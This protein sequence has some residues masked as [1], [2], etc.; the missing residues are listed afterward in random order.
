MGHNGNMEHDRMIG[1]DDVYRKLVE[2]ASQHNNFKM[3]DADD[4]FITITCD[5][6]NLSINHLTW[7]QLMGLYET[8]DII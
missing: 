2:I 5:G 1:D 6:R 8:W 7:L 4:E 3:C